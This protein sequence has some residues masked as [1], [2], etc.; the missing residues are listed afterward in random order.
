MTE[1]DSDIASPKDACGGRR[2]IT[3]AKHGDDCG[4]EAA[5]ALEAF[6]RV[7][8]ARISFRYSKT[9]TGSQLMKWAAK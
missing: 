4:I 8:P 3:V 7:F 6:R 9:R 5:V 2:K 1:A